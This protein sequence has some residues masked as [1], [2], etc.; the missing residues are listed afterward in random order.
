MQ[1]LQQ[2]VPTSPHSSQKSK[3]KE[4]A[5]G[6][7]DTADQEEP[8]NASSKENHSVDSSPKA[9]RGFY[10]EDEDSTS[11]ANET[12]TEKEDPLK[13]DTKMQG[14]DD[15]YDQ[16]QQNPHQINNPEVA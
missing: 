1:D 13:Y 7:E 4:F 2:E 3:T 16:P 10:D 12:F 11:E 6:P 8:N 5:D 14:N 15:K 9:N